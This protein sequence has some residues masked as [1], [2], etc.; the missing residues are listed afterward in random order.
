MAT[1]LFIIKKYTLKNFDDKHLSHK[2]YK[3]II[4]VK[5]FCPLNSSNNLHNKRLG[6][7]HKAV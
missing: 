4:L 5:K 7:A 2:I 6:Y 1:T 3:Q